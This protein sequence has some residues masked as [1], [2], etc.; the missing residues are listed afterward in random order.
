MSYIG[1]KDGKM[2]TNGK[3]HFSIL[4]FCPTIYLATLNVYKKLEDSGSHKNREICNINFIGEKEKWT[5]K[6]NGKQEEADTIQQ[7]IPNIYTKIQNP[8]FSS[9]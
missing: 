9:S 4:I 2:G 8:R 7:V 3:I 6:G 1:A 5:N